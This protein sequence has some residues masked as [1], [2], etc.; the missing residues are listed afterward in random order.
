[1]DTPNTHFMFNFFFSFRKSCNLCDKVEKSCRAGQVT[2]DNIAH[3][4]CMLDP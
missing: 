4:H 2:D 3:A 1:M